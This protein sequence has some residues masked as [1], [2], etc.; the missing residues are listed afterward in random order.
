MGMIWLNE[1]I[2]VKAAKSG[3]WYSFGNILLKGCLFFTLP[4]FTRI[5]NT[6]D[7]GIY[8]TYMAYEGLLAAVL[9]LGFYGT[10]KNAKFDFK[11]DFNNYLYSILSCSIFWLIIV[12]IIIFVG[13]KSV[14][15][16]LSKN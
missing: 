15:M 7:F 5:M 13:K 14:K 8:N 4:I 6:A 10:I 3:F 12:M 11:D 16:I 1:N 9:G 2:N